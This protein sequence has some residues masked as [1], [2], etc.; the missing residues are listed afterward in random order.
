MLEGKNYFLFHSITLFFHLVFVFYKNRFVE[1]DLQAQTLLIEFSQKTLIVHTS[2]LSD[3]VHKKQNCYEFI[4]ELE[5]R[6]PLFFFVILVFS[7]KIDT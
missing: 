6:S 5:A 1:F 3:F 2:Y 4:G 7:Y